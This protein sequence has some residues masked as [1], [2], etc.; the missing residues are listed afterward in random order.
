MGQLARAPGVAG[1]GGNA[2][3]PGSAGSQEPMR[4]VERTAAIAGVLGAPT[5]SHNVL[6]CVLLTVAAPARDAAVLDA[7]AVFTVGRSL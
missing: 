7:H 5:N 1:V 2:I 6:P 4:R 3:H